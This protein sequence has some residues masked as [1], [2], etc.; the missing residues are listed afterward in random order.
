MQ[1]SEEDL[2]ALTHHPSRL[3]WPASCF[4]GRARRLD[5]R[6]LPCD[7]WASGLGPFSVRK[8]RTLTSGCCRPLPHPCPMREGGVGVGEGQKPLHLNSF[9]CYQRILP[10]NTEKIPHMLISAHASRT[11]QSLCLPGSHLLAS[12]RKEPVP[13]GQSRVSLVCHHLEPCLHAHPALSPPL[14]YPL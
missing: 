6:V 7:A 4:V 10:Q 1:G 2:F 8:V 12:R 11:H 14:P 9:G 5:R 13:S 3:Q